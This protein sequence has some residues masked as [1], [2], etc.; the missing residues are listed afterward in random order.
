MFALGA[1][2]D[3]NQTTANEIFKLGRDITDTC[4]MSYQNSE[5]GLGGEVVDGESFAL[6]NSA[7][8]LRPETVESLF[9][10][11]KL[12][13]ETMYQDWGWNIVQAIETHCRD[14]A[15][16]H[17]YLHDPNVQMSFFMAETLKYLYLLF[18]DNSESVNLEHYVFNTEG[19][20]LSRRGHGRRRDPSRW[21]PIKNYI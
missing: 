5:T 13:N 20:I 2:Y 21:T 12:T 1:Q 4:Y 15:G 19:H 17:P 10:M 9:Y 6:D 3:T 14:E 16:Y 11:W 18:S 7:Y 8:A